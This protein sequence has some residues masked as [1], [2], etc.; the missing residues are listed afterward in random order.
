MSG[1]VVEQDTT[2]GRFHQFCT[3]CSQADKCGICVL[4]Q[5]CRFYN[6][7]VHPELQPYV[8]KV[9]RQGPM[10]V[11]RQAPNEKRIEV[12]CKDC[13]C[14]NPDDK[15]KYCLKEQ[16]VGCKNFKVNWRD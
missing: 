14:Y 12:V 11:H 10:T 2:D 16:K 1:A 5:N 3:S 8:M 4:S 15:S 6:T 7:S 13:S 9:E